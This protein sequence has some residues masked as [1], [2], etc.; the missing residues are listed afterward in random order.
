MLVHVA[1]LAETAAAHAARV[2]L[3]GVAHARVG[4]DGDRAGGGEVAL[5]ARYRRGRW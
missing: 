1:L 4:G 5:G 2:G 3:V